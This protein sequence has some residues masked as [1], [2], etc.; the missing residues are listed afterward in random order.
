M[1]GRRLASRAR[2][3]GRRHGLL[4]DAAAG[5]ARGRA[6]DL[7]FFV[8]A[9]GAGPRWARSWVVVVVVDAQ[10]AGHGVRRPLELPRAPAQRKAAGRRASASN[11][12]R[13]ELLEGAAELMLTSSSS[14]D[15][16]CWSSRTGGG[17][18]AWSTGAGSVAAAAPAVILR[19]GRGRR[20]GWTSREGLLYPRY[21]RYA[22]A[23]GRFLAP[24]RR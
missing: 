1:A 10:R 5:L 4:L 19:G 3:R 8:S 7:R 13:L 23:L 16:A 20:P 6:A 12:A 22:A 24:L 2:R 18:R 21:G 11:E 15:Q 9:S 17:R 14:S